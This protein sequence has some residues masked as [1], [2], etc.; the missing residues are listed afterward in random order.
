MSLDA[1]ARESN[2]R[3]SIKKFFVDNIQTTEGVAVTFDKALN[4]PLITG[5]E[6]DKWVS[7][8][9]GP[10]TLDTMS[11]VIF[12]IYCCTRRDN[13]GYK[14]SQLRDKVMGY[15]IDYDMADG[16]KRIDFYQSSYSGAWTLLGKLLVWEI[17]P[18]GDMLAAD[19][20]KFKVLT[21]ILKV[22]M[23]I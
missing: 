15:L 7:I 2:L 4:A 18:S 16:K 17:L 19:E 22:A 11:D 13:E 14:L 20:T 1:S 23:K 10:I 6:V 9:F 8:T 3:D 12:E 5:K 21:V